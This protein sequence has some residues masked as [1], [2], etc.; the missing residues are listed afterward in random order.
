MCF[1]VPKFSEDISYCCV[2]FPRKTQNGTSALTEN[3]KFIQCGL[4]SMKITI[5]PVKYHNSCPNSSQMGP[6]LNLLL[7]TGEKKTWAFLHSPLH[8][9]RRWNQ[10]TS[11]QL[12]LSTCSL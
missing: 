10:T 6:L 12:D 2:F 4:T 9:R 8:G 11:N 7:K 1:K 3:I 5:S